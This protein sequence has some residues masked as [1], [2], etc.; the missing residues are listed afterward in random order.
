MKKNFFLSENKDHIH[1]KSLKRHFNNV[2]SC[3]WHIYY[4]T[5]ARVSTPP[6]TYTHPTRLS[7]LISQL[8]LSACREAADRD[9][10]S[11]GEDAPTSDVFW[12]NFPLPSGWDILPSVLIKPFKIQLVFPSIPLKSPLIQQSL[13][14]LLSLNRHLVLL[15]K[16]RK[17]EKKTHTTNTLSSLEERYNDEDNLFP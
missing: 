12:D 4:H 16:K 2:N 13:G 3:V 5:R 6:P 7:F 11:K 1:N 14:F 15:F 9:P 17:K 10:E 8:E